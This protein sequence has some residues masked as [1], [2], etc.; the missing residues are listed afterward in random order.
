[1]SRERRDEFERQ[2]AICPTL[3]MPLTA[4]VFVLLYAASA[5]AQTSNDDAVLARRA[6]CSGSPLAAHALASYLRGRAAL[7]GGDVDAALADAGAAVREG[8]SFPDAHLLLAHALHAARRPDE[9]LR[10][11]DLL[12]DMPATAGCS[13][14]PLDRVLF[15]AGN[16]AAD[17][18]NNDAARRSYEEA[19]REAESHATG[20]DL[21]RAGPDIR[22]NLGQLLL[23][24]AGERG[25]DRALLRLAEE[26]LDA[27]ANT[28]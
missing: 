2:L 17:T 10:E 26:Q 6:H 11:L 18:G 27:A 25:H 4:F 16:I 22:N 1:M 19:L 5:A 28:P 21:R 13:P 8:P 3:A 15:N 23:R 24:M 12:R 9:A 20:P 14:I 7:A